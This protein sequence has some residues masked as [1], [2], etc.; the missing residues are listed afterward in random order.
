MDQNGL[1]TFT[2]SVSRCGLRMTLDLLLL[3]VDHNIDNNSLL[4]IN[5][6]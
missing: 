4:S 1:T 6:R 2:L 5:E 3:A